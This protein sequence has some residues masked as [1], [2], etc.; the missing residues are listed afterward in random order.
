MPRFIERRALDKNG[1]SEI[2]FFVTKNSNFFIV[3]FFFKIQNTKNDQ[4]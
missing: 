1:L 2:L 4:K 3:I